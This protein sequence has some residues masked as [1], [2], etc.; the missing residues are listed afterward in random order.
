MLLP[1]SS[2]PPPASPHA[3]VPQDEPRYSPKGDGGPPPSSKYRQLSTG[4]RTLRAYFRSGWAFL[5]PY[6]AAYLLYAWH[7]WPVNVVAAGSIEQGA[8]NW[9]PCLLHV[10]WLL[11]GLHLILGAIAL[12]YWWRNT[13]G[14]RSAK[15]IEPETDSEKTASSLRSPVSAAAYRLLPWLCLALLFWIPGVYLEFPADPWHHYARINEW[16]WLQ[17]VTE[18]SAWKKSS[19]FLAYSLIGQITPP[20]AQRQGFNVYYAGSCLLLC[21]QYFRLARAIG[22]G[23]RA[24]LIFVLLNALT[25]GNN[26]FGFYRYYGMSSSLFAQLGAV[27]LTRLAFE[28]A[29][30]RAADRGR[31][32]DRQS[33]ASLLPPLRALLPAALGALVLL[34][35]IAFNHVQGLGIAGFG[36]AAVVIWRLVEWRRSMSGWL[37]L[38]AILLSIATIWWWPRHRFL[39]ELYR[40]GGWLTSWYGFNF[41]DFASPTSIRSLQILGILGIGNLLAGLWLLVRRNEFVGWLTL[42]PLLL[43]SL[44]MVA[45]PF[46]NSLATSTPATGYY[47]IEFHRMLLAIPAGLAVV[48]ISLGDKLSAGPNGHGPTSPAQ[49]TAAGNVATSDQDDEPAGQRQNAERATVR[50]ELLPLSG[51]SFPS[52]GFSHL[53][54][55]LLLLVLVTADQKTYL[56]RF[57]NAVMV[58]ADDLTMRHVV[59]SPAIAALAAQPRPTGLRRLPAPVLVERGA[60][61]TTPGIGYAMNATGATLI[62]GTRKWM[63]WPTVTP[64]SLTAAEALEDI[65]YIEPSQV[66]P[67]PFEATSNLFSPLSMTG[68]ISGH[69]LPLEFALEHA[70]QKELSAARNPTPTPKRA[71]VIWL[72][73]FNPRDNRHFIATGADDIMASQ[74]EDRGGLNDP[75]NEQVFLSG[76]TLRLRPAMRTLDGDGARLTLIV[77]TPTISSQHEFIDRANPLGGDKRQYGE[78]QIRLAEPGR[79]TVEVTGHIL[80]PERIFTARYYFIVRAN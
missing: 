21:W 68:Y 37:A 39:D 52:P 38:A 5:I 26:I 19:Y 3:A 25:F 65:H 51:W 44:P 56:H 58:P 41:F 34:A 6:L 57:F 23:E 9:V 35:L 33:F 61:L 69:W 75:A 13:S 11:H 59:G 30:G 12:R 1:A 42:V 7:R 10:Y 45:I 74:R 62:T 79:Y 17:T 27:A 70:A 22:L 80:W 40:P 77:K 43:L 53:L 4:H 66:R 15:C 46:A 36:L 73:W 54:A 60:I 76:D 63:T 49:A 47:I 29:H 14:E 31:K 50:R 24:S 32:P 20:L 8:G 64:P 72:E 16:S 48:A 28:A 2:H 55:S 18:H 71:P 78:A 67:I